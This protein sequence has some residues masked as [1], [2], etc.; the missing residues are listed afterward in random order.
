MSIEAEI[1]T[2]LAN[3]NA[4]FEIRESLPGRDSELLERRL[5]KI[6][7]SL[8]N[9][10]S[11]IPEYQIIIPDFFLARPLSNS[12]RKL[13]D[14]SLGTFYAQRS[15]SQQEVIATVPI[16]ESSERML[17]LPKLFQERDLL[18][19]LSDIPFNKACGEWADKPRVFWT[20]ESMANRL[21]ILAE[22]FSKIDLLF[23]IEDAFRPVGVQEGLF[24]RRVGWIQNEHPDWDWNKV[25]L[26]A[27]SKTAVSPRLAS[28][29]SGAAIDITLRRISDG[30]SLDLG[31]KYLEGGALVAVDCPFITTEQ[32]QTRQLF[33]NSFRMAGFAIYDGEDWHASYQDNLAGVLDGKVINGYVAKYGP[34]KSFSLETGQILEVYDPGEYNEPYTDK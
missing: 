20:R 16:R 8:G 14:E 26:E 18:L 11:P 3:K 23:H 13:V 30:S 6:R 33:A 32:W 10:L 5:S 31:N 28:H 27:K 22:A 2:L 34:V 7:N 15:V 12:Q 29:K 21:L 1:S 4:G 17:F 24:K 25:L 19:S 9:S